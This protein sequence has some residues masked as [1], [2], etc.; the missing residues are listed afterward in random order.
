MLIPNKIIKIGDDMKKNLKMSAIRTKLIS[1]FFIK[2][3]KLNLISQDESD[4]LK[5]IV[6]DFLDGS[7][8]FELSEECDYEL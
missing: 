4:D 3:L 2:L 7:K 1:D 6:N 8:S 5:F